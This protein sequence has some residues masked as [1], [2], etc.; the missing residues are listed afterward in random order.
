MAFY[1]PNYA[2]LTLSDINETPVY[3]PPA[4]QIFILTTYHKFCVERIKLSIRL[5]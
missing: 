4:W 2:S 5:E 1:S 3:S